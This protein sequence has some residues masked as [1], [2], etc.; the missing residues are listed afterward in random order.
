MS[1]TKIKTIGHRGCRGRWPRQAELESI[2]MD[3]EQ[4]HRGLMETDEA[5]ETTLNLAT[6]LV[7]R[8]GSASLSLSRICRRPATC[9]LR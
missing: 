9:W 5:P 7:D 3:R 2:R 1:D 4:L 8:A 6:H